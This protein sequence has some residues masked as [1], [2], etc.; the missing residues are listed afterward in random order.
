MCTKN[1]F[2]WVV[3]L[4]SQLLYVRMHRTRT[5]HNIGIA[6]SGVAGATAIISANFF[7]YIVDLQYI[8]SKDHDRY[9]HEA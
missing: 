4:V 1:F 6:A 9:E 7:F 5:T 3:L 8:W 2:F